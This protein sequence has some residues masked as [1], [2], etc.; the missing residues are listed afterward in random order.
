MFESLTGKFQSVFKKLRSKGKLSEKDVKSALR[1]VRI[2]LLE[3]DVH[4]KVVKKFISEVE[5]E[6]LGKEV[7]ESLT[8]GQQVIKIVHEKLVEILGEKRE[9]ID[10]S[11]PRPVTVLMAGLQGSGKTTT[12]AKLALHY[13][14]RGLKP[15]LV[16]TDVHRPAAV[17]QLEKLA[18]M[19]GVPFYTPKSGESPKDIAIRAKEKAVE[20]A[21]DMLIVDTAG[22]FHVD[23]EMMEELREIKD[24]LSPR[25]T[26]LVV[27]AMTGQEAVNVA[28]RFNE[29]IGITGV[30]LTKLDGDARGGAALS[31][32]EGTGK[33]IKFMGVGEKLDALEPFYPERMA[34]RILGMG[35]VLT[36]IEKAQ[37]E[38]DER[39]AKEMMRRI[40]EASF[41][42]DD[43]KEQLLN[44]RKMGSLEEI[45]QSLPIP[46]KFKKIAGLGIG[47]N[48][49][50]KWIA[51]IDSMTVEERQNFKI[52]NG[53]RKKRIARGSGISVNDVNRL[54]KTY[55]DML[56]I[57]KQMKK[58]GGV[59][60]LLRQL[61]S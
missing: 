42:L 50:K 34:S 32:R 26:L 46:G 27:D 58:R 49:I 55:K 12:A 25:E 29:D 24:V 37:R 23:E 7:L 14:E 16:S 45:V 2:S 11:P 22:R 38:V 1:E 31:I 15:F 17:N 30:I 20:S 48:D 36:L 41:T 18:R 51:A 56:K 5:K 35:D 40:K 39:K 8:P 33:P 3:A 28:I 43:F 60:K 19:A 4:Y 59:G 53:S 47:E 6:A 57:M 10:L 13:K 54:L 9:D 21:S 61:F 52:I 44:I